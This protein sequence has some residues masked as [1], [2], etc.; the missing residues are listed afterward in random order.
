MPRVTCHLSECPAGGGPGRQQPGG[1][2]SAAGSA[3]LV[4]FT[5]APAATVRASQAASRQN[6]TCENAARAAR[7]PARSVMRIDAGRGWSWHASEGASSSACAYRISQGSRQK[8]YVLAWSQE[9]RHMREFVRKAAARA[10]RMPK[11]G[12]C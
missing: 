12:R 11:V 6:G 8:V 4:S 9:K 2:A 10:Q 5:V 3:R 7:P 1:R